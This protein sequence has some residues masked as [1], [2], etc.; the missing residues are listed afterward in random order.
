MSAFLSYLKLGFL[1]ITDF[2]GYDHMLFLLALVAG[3]TIQEWKDVLGLAT[4]FTLGH[5]LTLILVSLGIVRV[6]SN[7]VEFL[8]PLTIF[9]TAIGNLSLPNLNFR[10][11]AKL[12]YAMVTGFG[13][14]HGMGFSGYLS[15]LLGREANV[16]QPLLAFNIGIELGQ[17]LILGAMI[18]LAWLLTGPLKLSHKWWRITASLVAACFA[19]HLMWAYIV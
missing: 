16:F 17:I 8:I 18:L 5:S 14:I 12:R 6:N 13:L 9:L 1:H 19:L 10:H 2:A 3:Y 7:L 15:S 11:T 4:A